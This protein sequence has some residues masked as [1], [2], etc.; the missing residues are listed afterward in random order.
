M[1]NVSKDFND[2]FKNYEREVKMKVK[3]NGQ[4][5]S[6]HDIVSATFEYGSITGS[7]FA[8]GSTFSNSLKLTFCKLVE[9]LKQLD[10]VVAEIGIVLPDGKTEFVPMGVFI[11][12]EEVRQ[13]RNE[14]RT[15]IE[16]SDRMIMLS[17][18][19]ESELSYPAKIR[20]VALEVAN[21]S[22][23]KVDEANFNRL[24]VNTIEKP[25]G[26]TYREMLGIIAQFHVGYA[27]FDRNGLLAIRKLNTT[28]FKVTPKEYFLKG[29]ERNEIMFRPAGIEV[30]YGQGENDVFKIGNEKGSVIKL[31]NRVMTEDLLRSMYDEIKSL[32]FYPYDLKW[33]GNPAF[34]AGD[35]FNVTDTKGN[36]FNVPNLSYK[37]EF[38]GGLTATSSVETVASN[39]VKFGY[40]KILDQVVEYTNNAIESQSGSTVHVGVEEPDKA[41]EGDIW[42]KEDGDKNDILEY[43]YNEET[44]E[45]EWKVVLSSTLDEEIAKE[46]EKAK[47]DAKNAKD[48][49]DEVAVSLVEVQKDADEAKASAEQSKV[50][51]GKAMVD[52]NKALADAGKALNSSN[53]N[54]VSISGLTVKIDE[55][56]AELDLKASK[57]DLNKLD[58]TV[59]NQQTQ[60]S[61]NAT[62]IKTKASQ[63]EVNTLKG[64]VTNQ[65]T[66][67]TQN[68]NEIKQ[69]ASQSLV[70]SINNKV[71]N[72]QAQ[73][74]LNSENIKLKAEKS[75]VT[76][77]KNELDGLE[78]GGTNLFTDT[79]DKFKKITIDGWNH[80]PNGVSYTML[81]EEGQQYV[82]RA[83]IKNITSDV[84]VGLRF[85]WYSKDNKLIR[86]NSSQ[87]TPWIN[88]GKSGYFVIV[89][90][91]PSGATGLRVSLRNNSRT[92]K[93][94]IEYRE[95]KVE[96]GNKPT[97]W[98]PAPEDLATQSDVTKLEASIN[99][100]AG[101]ITNLTS[102]VNKNT[103]NIGKLTI[104]SNKIS[105][106]VVE[107]QNQEISTQ[108]FFPYSF[109][110]PSFTIN[111]NELTHSGTWA[112][113]IVNNNNLRKMRLVGGEK[114]RIKYQFRLD[115]DPSSY[116]PYHQAQHGTLLLYSGVDHSKYPSIALGGT[117][118]NVE[119]AK[120]WKK[121]TIVDRE[122]VF[123]MPK[124]ISPQTQYRIIGYTFRAMNKDGSFAKPL[125][126]T[127]LNVTIQK[128]DVFTGWTPAPEDL[129]TQS[130]ITQLSD[131]ILLRVQKGDVINQI[132]VSTE[133]V[134]IQG[135][136]IHITGQTKIDNAVI[137]NAM[138]ADGSITNAKIQNAT[139]TSAKI[140]QLDAGKITTGE[141]KSIL[142][143]G[144]NSYWDL[145]TGLFKMYNPTD[146]KQQITIQ[147]GAFVSTDGKGRTITIKDD[148]LNANSGNNNIYLD[149]KMILFRGEGYTRHLELQGQGL[150]ISSFEQ[151]TGQNEYL[152]AGLEIE[153]LGTQSYIDFRT[154]GRTNDF[155]TRIKS[156]EGATANGQGTLQIEAKRF[157]TITNEVRFREAQSIDFNGA[158]ANNLPKNLISTAI[159][160]SKSVLAIEKSDTGD[161]HYFNFRMRDL[162]HGIRDWGVSTWASDERLK[163]NIEPTEISGLGL[164]D[165][166]NVVQFDWKAGG[167]HE[168][169][170]LIAQ[171][172]EKIYPKAVFENFSE[173]KQLKPEAFVP[174]LIKAIQELKS[175][176]ERMTRQIIEL[177]LS[178]KGV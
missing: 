45:Y 67:I 94:T 135:K 53:E 150:T 77:L 63:T 136:K 85:F 170:G 86:E 133:G 100:E 151:K 31:E 138:I 99:V 52:A 78:I 59:K 58:G 27:T 68:A 125:K 17:D 88:S 33:R 50:D 108:N 69:K 101:K 132:N 83:Y 176:N 126:G 48:K 11:I 103:T 91:A 74:N 166:L 84:G 167:T 66:Q 146:N 29:L 34:E 26:Y 65:Q 82:V 55:V 139:I 75:E 19:Y 36:R 81:V 18:P 49:A 165:K 107:L 38:K 105:S 128:G 172:V 177:Q 129:A 4:E 137:K 23:V 51:A 46:I 22:G 16:C 142:I 12:S 96:K 8:I 43:V 20:D 159:K 7:D 32:N 104:E 35:W 9:G 87:D 173:I 174:V 120:T 109:V 110:E 1:L 71:T 140:A 41:K 148:Y 2:A 70:D 161:N 54:K 147:N 90:T 130:Q 76:N 15:T 106:Q 57:Q 160:G 169:I 79:S 92:G 155:D 64:T 145:S 56:N 154:G 116:I 47:E 60:I 122:A 127:F 143:T 73:I 114:Y 168:S 117:H 21:L 112:G 115:E 119:D 80:Y 61:Q 157:E 178:G 121:G 164:V 28:D 6:N 123:T 5:Y 24:S 10:E 102:S 152:N 171:E 30:R 141:L 153:S 93:S 158:L 62:D 98:S 89:D 118:N 42:F 131:D 162:N 111:Q 25:V 97:A 124:D 39:K 113:P 37:L 95:L 144:A 163:M 40:K 3:I 134:L 14:N 175:D 44:G 13:D 156:V 149:P 72:Q